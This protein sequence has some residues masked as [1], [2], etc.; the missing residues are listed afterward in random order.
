MWRK[1]KHTK[2]LHFWIDNERGLHAGIKSGGK[3]ILWS[4][5]G[6]YDAVQCD[7]LNEALTIMSRVIHSPGEKNEQK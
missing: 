3:F 1:G 4:N 2:F 7:D 6:R 5:H